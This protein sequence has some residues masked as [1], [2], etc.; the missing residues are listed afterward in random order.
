MR[1]LIADDHEVIRKGVIR[2]LR[3]HNETAELLEATNGKE[4]VEKAIEWKPNLI[5]LDVR[6]PC[7]SGFEV[8][9]EIRERDP[10]IRILFFSIH[11]GS[12]ILDQAMLGGDGFILK[13]KIVEMLPNAI[14]ALSHRQRFFPSISPADFE[15]EEP[16]IQ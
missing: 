6:L 3:A 4:A 8:A 12:E 10:L 1:I 11:G 9:K 16:G 7:L 14:Y 5:L 2:V 13:D 15:D